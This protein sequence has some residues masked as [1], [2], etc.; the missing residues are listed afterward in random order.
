MTRRLG[1]KVKFPIQ[2][3]TEHRRSTDQETSGAAWADEPM[4]VAKMQLLGWDI[5]GCARSS[6]AEYQ[7]ATMVM[8]N[9]E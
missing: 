6:E 4:L 8:E 5:K 3:M 9:S 7:V 2:N 1:A